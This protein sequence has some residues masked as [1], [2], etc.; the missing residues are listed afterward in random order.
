LRRALLTVVPAVASAALVGSCG[1]DS[2][3]EPY[4]GGR[5]GAGQR[6]VQLTIRA[7]DGGGNVEEATLECDGTADASGFS[8]RDPARLC[9]VAQRLASFLTRVPDP[10]R[11]CTQIYG[12]PETARVRGTIEGREVDRRLSRTNGCEIADWDRLA[13]LLPIEATGADRPGPRG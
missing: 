8:G 3:D 4:A 2:S 12:G 9:A 7:N 11:A 1:G 10:R 13:L 6:A 5:D